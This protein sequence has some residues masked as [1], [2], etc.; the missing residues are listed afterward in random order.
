VLEN[1]AVHTPPGTPLEIVGRI[2]NGSVRLE[3]S[4]AG[5]G[6][7]PGSRDR[8]FDKF[9]RLSEGGSGTGLGLAIAKAATEAQGGKLRIED[10]PLG[11]AR[12]VLLVPNALALEVPHA[13]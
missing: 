13:R 10:S 8:V 12:L 9:Q 3:V 2:H 7:P 1:V 4:D 5:P 11:G 6:I